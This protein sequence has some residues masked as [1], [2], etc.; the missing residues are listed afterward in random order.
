M[1]DVKQSGDIAKPDHRWVLASSNAGKLREF[2]ALFQQAG[3]Q[4]VSQGELG[5]TEA[6]EPFN[7]FLE[8]A[9]AKARHAS[10][11]TG[12]PAI[13]DDSG[14]TVAALDGAPGV[15]SARYADLP[16]GQKSDEANNRKLLGQMETHADRSAAF[17][18][19]LAFVRHADDPDPVIARGQ[20]NGELARSPAGEGGF[21]YDP[22][23][24]IPSLGQ[25]AAQL[26]AA[27]KNA[28][29]H[30]A[31]ALR[32]LLDALKAAGLV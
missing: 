29:S 27:V 8:N 5:V 16:D 30:R 23:F 25:H 13:A 7:T 12:L 24:F 15:R 22:L 32:Q 26:P 4:I 10:R 1:A 2:S 31:Q 28:V 21:G 11:L 9:L 19:L 18:C 20:W 17:V 14:L 6:E 3:I